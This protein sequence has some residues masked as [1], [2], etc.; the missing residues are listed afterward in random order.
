MSNT[1][2]DIFHFVVRQDGPGEAA[3]DECWRHERLANR[4]SQFGYMAIYGKT[5]A[6]KYRFTNETEA[7]AMNAG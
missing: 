7:I 4:Q 1:M 3:V 2:H 6:F 5:G